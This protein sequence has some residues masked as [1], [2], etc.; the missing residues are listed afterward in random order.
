MRSMTTTLF[1]LAGLATIA[2]LPARAD[3]DEVFYPA[4][5]TV[6]HIKINLATGEQSIVTGADSSARD[7]HLVWDCTASTGYFTS[8]IDRE[9]LDWGDIDNAA[10]A[11]VSHFQLGYCAQ[12][13]T[14]DPLT[15]GVTLQVAFYI[16]ENGQN[17]PMPPSTATLVLTIAHMPGSIDPNT[18]NG[19]ANCWTVD[20][21]LAEA[22]AI[23]PNLPC[24]LGLG[25][26]SD[27]DHDGLSDFGYGYFVPYAPPT[28]SG[29]TAAAG[30]M[31]QHPMP[32]VGAPGADINHYDR[33]MPPGKW[34]LG[35][36]GY[37]ATNIIVIHPD[38]SS[39]SGLYQYHLQLFGLGCGSGDADGD[40]SC[41]NIDNCPT[42]ANADQLDTD[43]DGLGD[44]C[45][46]CP[47]TPCP[48]GHSGC[49]ANGCSTICPAPSN[50]SNCGCADTD[51]NGTVDLVDLSAVLSA[52]GDGGIN[53]P[54]DCAS[55][56]GAIDIADLAYTLARYG[57]T[58]CTIP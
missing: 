48:I 13:W 14:P 46:N 15:D 9:R 5:K 43:A 28:R 21:D 3:D 47:T 36:D 42:F 12:S 33:F 41:N 31:I 16:N 53:L 17:S 55:P 57:R 32:P 6:G 18:P 35:N 54:G 45:D 49:D 39:D 22:C 40:G 11:S 23:D 24:S 4:S 56:C 50:L 26:A 20:I 58:N 34:Q 19:F 2:A 10:G 29:S 27:L 30:P 25:G 52:Y 1:A 37:V 51:D 44:A 7:Q 8:V 38:G